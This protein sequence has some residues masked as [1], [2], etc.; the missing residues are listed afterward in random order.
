ML[1]AVCL[2]SAVCSCLSAAL[3]LCEE[4]VMVLSAAAVIFGTASLNA[5]VA[6]AKACH[7]LLIAWHIHPAVHS[8]T[9]QAPVLITALHQLRHI[10]PLPRGMLPAHSPTRH[11]RL[12]ECA[13]RYCHKS[14]ALVA[15]EAHI[16]GVRLT[17]TH[18]PEGLVSLLSCH[19]YT[20]GDMQCG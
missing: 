6:V 1:A 13:A 10:V 16:Q 14:R 19:G 4:Q 20:P 2:D 5:V 18:L 17:R 12:L 3:L 11:I 8:Q 15:T 7:C 9:G